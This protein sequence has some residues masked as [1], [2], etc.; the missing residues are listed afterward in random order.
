MEVLREPTGL[1]LSQRK[2]TLDLLKEFDCIDKQPVSSPL[3]PAQKLQAN[4]GAVISIPTLYRYLIG[5][6]NYLTQT[7]TVLSFTIQHL[8]QFMQDPRQP[9]LDAALRVLHYLLKDLGLGLF[10]TATASFKLQPFCESNW[11]TCP[12]SRRSVSAFYVSLGSSPISWKSKKQASISLTSAEAEYRSMRRVVVKITWLI[13]LFDDI[14]A[15]ITLLVSLHSDSQAAL[16][17]AKNPVFHE[18]T[19]HVEIDCHFVRQQFLA[20]LIS[21]SFVRS[22]SQ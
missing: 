6:L 19:K 13:R 20:G 3:D 8:S 18:R 12:D 21:L 22:D 1:I 16:H 14:S 4:T 15:P 5:K 11:G 17:I 7:R 10:M 9:H 2:F